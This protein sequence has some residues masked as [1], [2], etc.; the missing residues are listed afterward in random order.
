[1]AKL[2]ANGTE[3]I[4]IRKEW[5]VED[6]SHWA[7][8]S[9]RSNRKVLTKHGFFMPAKGNRM[10]HKHASGWSI[11]RD[12]NF[13]PI[14]IRDELLDNTEELMRI[15]NLRWGSDWILK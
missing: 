13:K 10:E 15:I 5:N 4:R 1:M 11:M 12:K 8:R 2:R 6:E 3:I 14:L 9:F 7:E